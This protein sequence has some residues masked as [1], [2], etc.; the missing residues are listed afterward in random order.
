MGRKCYPFGVVWENDSQGLCPC[1]PSR[2]FLQ[3][4][5]PCTPLETLLQKGLKTSQNL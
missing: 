1:T 3:G 2:A 4:L 5:C